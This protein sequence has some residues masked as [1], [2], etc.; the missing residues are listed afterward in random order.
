MSV[1]DD[2]YSKRKKLRE[3]TDKTDI[4]KYDNLPEELRTQIIFI[5]DDAIG[6]YNDDLEITEKPNV[7]WWTIHYILCREF[8]VFALSN[9]FSDSYENCRSYLLVEENIDRV[10][11]LIELS[12][13]YIE[14]I[15]SK[16]DD[17]DKKNSDAS[18]SADEAID[19]LNTRF[20][21]HGVG[22]QYVCQQIIRMDS[23]YMHTEITLPA[24]TLLQKSGFESSLEEL[25]EAHKHYK[26]GKNKDAIS[27]ALKAFESTMKTIINNKR[28]SV[29]KNATA[30]PLL[31]AC[32]SNGLIPE[33]MR[34]HFNTLRAT[35]E[36]GLPTVSN[37]L[38]RHGQGQNKVIIPNYI[39]AYALH[40]AAVNVTLLIDLYN[41]S[42]ML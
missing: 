41:E 35:L 40:L 8:G 11:S 23:E 33:P 19:E 21:E 37:R 26:D 12:F 25:L 1:Y 38:A 22:Y 7:V 39:A 42:N 2:I 31:D 13:K 29:D 18:M 36:N 9:E 5:W 3:N 14:D 16:Y 30:K 32:F 27:W 24:L 15:C 10:L 34:E 28:W 4:Y 6:P 17:I 20:K